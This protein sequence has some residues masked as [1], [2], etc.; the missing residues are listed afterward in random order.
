M[1]FLLLEGRSAD[2]EPGLLFFQAFQEAAQHV[3]VCNDSYETLLLVHYR[4]AAHFLFY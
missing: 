1:G 4:D 3:Y 2:P